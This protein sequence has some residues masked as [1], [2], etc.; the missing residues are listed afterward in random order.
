MTD[1]R[2]VNG[3]VGG[4]SS[5]I[6]DP[7]LAI[8]DAASQKPPNRSRGPNELRKICKYGCI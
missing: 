4:T 7:R 6:F 1:R 2:R 3:P 5:V 8:Q